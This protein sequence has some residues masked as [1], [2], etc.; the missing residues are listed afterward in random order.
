MTENRGETMRATWICDVY[1]FFR[2]HFEHCHKLHTQ[3]S[4]VATAKQSLRLDVPL[5]LSTN[6]RSPTPRGTAPSRPV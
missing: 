2:F 1:F 5:R 3:Y 4:P 6:S